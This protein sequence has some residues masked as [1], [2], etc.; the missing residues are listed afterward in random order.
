MKEQ[1]DL[2]KSQDKSQRKKLKLKFHLSTLVVT[3]HSMIAIAIVL[4]FY[5][6]ESIPS[7][8]IDISTFTWQK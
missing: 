1:L 2:L 4:K 8:L 5:N 3:F 6:V 7:F